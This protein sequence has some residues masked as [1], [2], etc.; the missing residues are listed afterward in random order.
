MKSILLCRG[1]LMINWNFNWPKLS[2]GLYK[3][4]SI[5]IIRH[6]FSPIQMISELKNLKQTLLN[7][8][9]ICKYGHLNS[10]KDHFHLV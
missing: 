1:F 7:G 5:I 9:L 3:N 2:T 8:L 10:Q 4:G 6:V